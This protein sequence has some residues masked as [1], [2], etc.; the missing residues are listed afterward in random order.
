MSVARTEKSY[1]QVVSPPVDPVNIYGQR[2]AHGF[3]ISDDWSLGLS[4]LAILWVFTFTGLLAS[5]FPVAGQVIG[6]TVFSADCI[7][8]AS[9][10]F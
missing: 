2:A 1:P 4:C 3:A 5:R 9:I 8:L 6:W 7:L 10:I